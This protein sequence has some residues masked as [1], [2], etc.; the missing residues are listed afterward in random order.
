[1]KMTEIPKTAS[2]LD[3][4][5]QKLRAELRTLE[6]NRALQKLES[7]AKLRHVR[8]DIARVLTMKSQLKEQA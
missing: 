4:L 6:L 8:R 5:E 2:E 1:M 7:P 3:T